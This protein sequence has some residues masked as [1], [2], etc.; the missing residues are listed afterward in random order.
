MLTP[1]P[2]SRRHLTFLLPNK[3][4]LSNKNTENHLKPQPD[5]DIANTPHIP[6]SGTDFSSSASLA[7][8]EDLITAS[9][10]DHTSFLTDPLTVL[11]YSLG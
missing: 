5:Q 8:S 4:S 3:I 11:L 7:P 1:T 10:I 6:T 9:S 2:P